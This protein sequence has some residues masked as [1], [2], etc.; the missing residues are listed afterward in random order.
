M[1]S[2]TWVGPCVYGFGTGSVHFLSPQFFFFF[3]INKNIREKKKKNQQRKDKVVTTL[4]YT[5]LENDFR[6]W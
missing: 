1:A 3:S 5:K 4:Q 2:A 6:F